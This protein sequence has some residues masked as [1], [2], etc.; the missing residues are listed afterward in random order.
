MSVVEV[1]E[2][3]GGGDV[4]TTV[5]EVERGGGRWDRPRKSARIKETEPTRRLLA[6]GLAN[7]VLEATNTELS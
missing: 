2:M 5:G 3:W 7:G 6:C 4:G 1:G